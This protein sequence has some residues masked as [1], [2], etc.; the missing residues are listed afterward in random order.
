M[1]NKSKK[2]K[3]PKPKEIAILS[4]AEIEKYVRLKYDVDDNGFWNWFFGECPWGDTNLLS[5]HED[6][7]DIIQPKMKTYF[8]IL[9][10]DFL[11]DADEELCLEIENDL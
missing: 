2:T 3:K 5:L 4:A 6:D 11:P 7:Y 1:S 9:K 10:D 8:N